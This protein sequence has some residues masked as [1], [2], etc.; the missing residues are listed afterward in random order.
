[1]RVCHAE[2][3]QASSHLFPRALVQRTADIAVRA[4]TNW[5]AKVRG[6]IAV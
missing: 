6:C 5:P 4:T 1:M 2:S 3:K